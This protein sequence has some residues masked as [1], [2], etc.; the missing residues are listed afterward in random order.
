MRLLERLP[1]VPG[2]VHVRGLA[3]RGVRSCHRTRAKPDVRAAS[4]VIR[5][6]SRVVGNKAR[7]VLGVAQ[8]KAAGRAAK[9]ADRASSI[10]RQDSRAIRTIDV[11]VFA[12]M[13]T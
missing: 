8:G 3:I 4:R 1:G 5:V 9:G 2:I 6:G 11:W 12:Q 13:R 7:V 10:G